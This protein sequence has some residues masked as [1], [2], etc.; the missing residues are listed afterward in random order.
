ML[1]IL[2]KKLVDINTDFAMEWWSLILHHWTEVF[3]PF[4]SDQ[5]ISNMVFLR[6]SSN[7][8]FSLL[9]HFVIN[10]IVFRM[11]LLNNIGFKDLQKWEAQEDRLHECAPWMSKSFALNS[12]IILRNDA[13]NCSASLGITHYKLQF[14]TNLISGKAFVYRF[15]LSLHQKFTNV[16]GISILKGWIRLMLHFWVRHCDDY[17]SL[18]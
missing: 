4:G 2:S 18:F 10:F 3:F 12:A 8:L 7:A 5:R 13:T 16:F 15:K 1:A 14:V 6:D 11:E 9:Y 17:S